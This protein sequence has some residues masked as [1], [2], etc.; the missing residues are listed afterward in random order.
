MLEG[1]VASLAAQRRTDATLAEMRAVLVEGW[2]HAAAGDLAGLP[3]LN[4]RFHHL[5]AE[6]AGNPML[7]ET[8]ERLRHLI[9]WIYSQR[10]AQRAPRSW[11]EHR[12]I[13]DAIATR[14]RRHRRAGRG[15]RAYRSGPRRLLG[16]LSVA[17][18]RRSEPAHCATVDA[19]DRAGHERR[20][21]AAQE[22]DDVGELRRRVPRRPIG[23]DP[24]CSARTSSML[25]PSC[26]A[27]A[28]SKRP[29]AGVSN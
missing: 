17:R 16:E 4:T 21:G 6:V 13:V 11:H 28:A 2:A 8:I 10:I 3:A 19:N 27:R 15:A 1:L 26:R 25:R 20:P 24:M 18:R 5:L 12:Q 23:I 22:G 14:R 9:E 29:S 7:A